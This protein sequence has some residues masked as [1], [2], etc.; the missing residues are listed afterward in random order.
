M[1]N[2]GLIQS[3]LAALTDTAER[4]GVYQAFLEAMTNFTVGFP[5]P[6]VVQSE[7]ASNLRWYPVTFTT[8]TVANREV[9]I[10]HGLPVTPYLIIPVLDPSNVGSGIPQLKVTRAADDTYLYVSSPV[11]AVPVTIFVEG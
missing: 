5:E 3:Y 6:G 2:L 11:T 1:A 9:A 4:N 7:R 8:S 10:A